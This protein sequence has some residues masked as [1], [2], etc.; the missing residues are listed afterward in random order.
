ML[1]G[2]VQMLSGTFRTADR[3]WGG[4]KVG[5]FALGPHLVRGPSYIRKIEIL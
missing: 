3:G 2:R 5:H 1:Q 4:G